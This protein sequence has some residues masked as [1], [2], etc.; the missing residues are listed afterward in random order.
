MGEIGPQEILGRHD[1]DHPGPKG[2]PHK[3]ATGAVTHDLTG[4]PQANVTDTTTDTVTH[5]P[6]DLPHTTV[7]GAVIHS[8]IPADRDS[9]QKAIMNPDVALLDEVLGRLIGRRMT[10][11]VGGQDLRA[12][13]FLMETEGPHLHRPRLEV[14]T[15]PRMKRMRLGLRGLLNVQEGIP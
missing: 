13:G 12:A 3:T 7:T 4:L 9:R 11:T 6:T 1:T 2:P 5:N 8:H 14:A 10:N 15:V